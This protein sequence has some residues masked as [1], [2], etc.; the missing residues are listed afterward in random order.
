MKRL[1]KRSGYTKL[2]YFHAGEYG[3]NYGRPHYHAIIFGRS[4]LEGATEHETT[5]RGDTTWRSP[6]LSELWPAGLNR[7]GTVTF[8]SCAYVA[9]YVTKKVF[10]KRAASHYERFSTSTGE[11]YKLTPEYCTMS[12]RPGIGKVHFD[13][14][15]R[16]IYPADQVIT[17]GKKCKPP[18]YYDKQ[19]EKIDPAAY[20]ILKDH[21]EQALSLKPELKSPRHLQAAETIKLA[22]IGQLKR[23][24]EIG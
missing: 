13:R 12:R 24:Y 20:E 7:V 8:E 2:R 10:G 11:V 21:R 17:R 1:R 5:D 18:K 6:E 15:S 14:Y 4:F 9:R 23:R 3:E 16:E 22:Q 19:L